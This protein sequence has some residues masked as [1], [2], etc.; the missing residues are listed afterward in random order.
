MHYSSALKHHIRRTLLRLLI[1]VF[2]T[3]GF[4]AVVTLLLNGRLSERV[5]SA[6]ES[7]KSVVLDNGKITETLDVENFLPCAVMG[8]LSIE[9]DEELLKSFAVIMRTYIFSVMGAETSI[10]V[11]SLDIPYVTYDE[12]ETLWGDDFPANYNRLMKIVSDTSLKTLYC[13][14]IMISPYYHSV[15]AGTTRAGS[16][17][18]GESYSYLCAAKCPNDSASP[19]YFKA[20]YYTNEEFA[21][22]VRLM[23]ERISVDPASPLENL[24]IISR[25]SSGYVLEMSVGG[26]TFDGTQF[27]EK[28]KINSPSFMIEEYN[29]GVRI[30]TYGKGHGLGLSL[31]HAA[32]MAAGGS[33]YQEILHYF[34][35]DVEIK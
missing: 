22:L 19:D 13:G 27:Y 7:G 10:P 23:D 11:S 25:D 30:S 3:L 12:L 18:L 20:Y 15:S 17:V 4:P 9:N 1:F 29:G 28:A 35:T 14:D 2:I 33:S 6:A 8:Q 26:I 21:S 24:Q 34:Y 16:E 31:N 5:Y 32:S